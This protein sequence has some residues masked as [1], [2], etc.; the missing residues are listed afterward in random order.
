MANPVICI[1]DASIKNGQLMVSDLFPNKSQAS[2]VIDPAPQ[3][4]RY[5]RVVENETPSVS[6]LVVTRDVSGLSAYFLVTLDVDGAGINPTVAQA[7]AF[8]NAVIAEMR[9]GADLSEMR[10]VIGGVFNDDTG[11]EGQLGAGSSTATTANILA[12]LGGAHFTVP[13]GTDVDD[14]YISVAD[15]ASLFDETVYAPI[16]DEDSSFHISLAEGFLSKAK[17]ARVDPR[18]NEALDPL[19][20]VYG[21]DGSLL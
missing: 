21:S 17:S 6:N 1:R 20:V 11:L 10:D 18:T 19:V 9:N 16:H 2:A 4:P 5:L 7:T 14:A 13:A 3:G 12:I 15:Q 8:A